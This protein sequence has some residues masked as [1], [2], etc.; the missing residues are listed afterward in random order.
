MSTTSLIAHNG[1]HDAGQKGKWME[2]DGA[3]E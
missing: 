1:P 2:R 3:R